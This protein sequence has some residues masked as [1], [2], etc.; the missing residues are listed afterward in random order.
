MRDVLRNRAR[1]QG[2]RA[3]PEPIDEVTFPE[4]VPFALERAARLPA[5]V[6]V[7]MPPPN[8]MPETAD[9]LGEIGIEGAAGRL[10]ARGATRAIFVSPEGDAAAVAAVLVAREVADAGLRVLLLDLT[11]SGAASRPMVH[12][13]SLPGITDLLASEA[14]FTDA[15]HQDRH[16]D[17]HVIPV[18]TAEPERAMRSADR[19]PI[20]MDSLTAA[21]DLV[22][23][24]CGP[25]DPEGI[26]RLVTGSTEVF[27]SLIEDEAESAGMAARLRHAGHGGPMLVT[28][29]GYRTPASR[30]R[31]RSAA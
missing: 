17:C 14:Q 23:V 13:I 2:S 8:A 26:S 22:V 10:V 9:C 27:V 25:T 1:R 3:R 15:I 12:G 11:A 6:D 7:P 18:G 24:E 5:P 19:L 30:M 31:D 28:P 21:Y 16:S 29:A 20:I 4:T